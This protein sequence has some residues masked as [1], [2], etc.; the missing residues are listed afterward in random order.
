M[1]DSNPLCKWSASSSENTISSNIPLIESLS[2]GVH[3]TLG[4]AVGDQTGAALNTISF[5]SLE[6]HKEPHIP[7]KQPHPHQDQQQELMPF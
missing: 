1:R 5:Q 7:G 3:S 6:N 2:S 4:A